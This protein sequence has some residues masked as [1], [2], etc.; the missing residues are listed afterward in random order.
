MSD[1]IILE[2]RYPDRNAVRDYNY[3]V[4]YNWAAAYELFINGIKENGA[5]IGGMPID[6]NQFKICLNAGIIKVIS[7]E[8]SDD[9]RERYFVLKYWACLENRYKYINELDEFDVHYLSE[10]CEHLWGVN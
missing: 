4:E 6:Y 8:T 1:S 3:S 5:A 9:D 2:R 10:D 7:V